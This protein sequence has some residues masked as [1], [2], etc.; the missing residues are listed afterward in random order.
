MWLLACAPEPPVGWPD[1][2]RVPTATLSGTL[3]W[4]V[5]FSDGSDCTYARTYE[6]VEDRSIDWSCPDCDVRYRATVT[7]VDDGCRTRITDAPASPEEWIGTGAGTFYRTSLPYTP[8][9]S[10]GAAEEDGGAVA[11]SW[12]TDE[13]TATP[14]GATYTL[15]TSGTLTAGSIVSD[16]WHGYKPPD[17]YVC[18]WPK[19]DPPPYRGDYRLDIGTPVPDALF[20]DACDQGL[21]L[22]DL[23]GR[24]VVM[25]LAA[26]DCGPCQ[27]AAA[28]EEPFVD[29]LARDGIEVVVVTLLA[30]TLD[31]VLGVTDTALRADWADTFGLSGPVVWD[32]GYGLWVLGEAAGEGLAY[33]TFAV[34]S[35][36]GR[37]LDVRTGFASWDVFASVIADDR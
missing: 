11:V 18:G 7:L 33:P 5:G 27:A 4:T 29:E 24:Y 36:T 16:P 35:P 12:S 30:P 15:S 28:L 14:G 22:G 37:V 10:Q 3:V 2:V 17:A 1:P 8:M 26:T 21:R 19:A 25:E 32:R 9:G 34:L 20:A 23:E 13:T 6:A 31:D